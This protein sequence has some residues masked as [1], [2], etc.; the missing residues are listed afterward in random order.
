[1]CIGYG[2]WCVDVFCGQVEWKVQTNLTLKSEK[3]ITVVKIDRWA[4]RSSFKR[5]YVCK[6]GS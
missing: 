3:Q 4:G 2:L 5:Y 6:D 1:M